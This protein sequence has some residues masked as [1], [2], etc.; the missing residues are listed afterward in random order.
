MDEGGDIGE[1]E[2][3]NVDGWHGYLAALAFAR[4]DFVGQRVCLLKKETR[5]A[6]TNGQNTT[7]EEVIYTGSEMSKGSAREGSTPTRL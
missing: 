5:Q 4:D 3:G 1:T 7:A 2:S 6:K